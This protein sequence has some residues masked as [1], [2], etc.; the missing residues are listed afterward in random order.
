LADSDI[1]FENPRSSHTVSATLFLLLSV[2]EKQLAKLVCHYLTPTCA[3]IEVERLFSTNSDVVT[4][5]R[6][7]LLPEKAQKIL[8]LHKD[9]AFL[10]FNY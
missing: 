1:L 4:P 8:Y 6:N 2:G 10:M 3:P 5:E 7:L 9:M